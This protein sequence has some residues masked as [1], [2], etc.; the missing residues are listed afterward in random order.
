MLNTVSVPQTKTIKYLGIHLDSKF[1]W[2][3]YIRA[4]LE[5]IRIKKRNINWLTN[6]S[7][8]PGVDNKLLIYREIIKPIWTYG[9]ELWSMAA[10][11]HIEIEALQSIILR[12][13]VN[14]PWCILVASESKLTI[15]VHK[16]W[17]NEWDNMFDELSLEDVYI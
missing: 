5:H 9:I 14:A 7:S 13:I 17:R 6:K 15:S 1:T 2:K 3:Y 12:T 8:K 4:K 16:N 11:G 10:K